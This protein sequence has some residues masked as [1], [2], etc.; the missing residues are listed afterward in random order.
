MSERDEHSHDALTPAEG[1]PSVNP[2]EKP[3]SF[4]EH[5]EELRGTIIKS[6]VT[7]VV[8][9]VL[10]GIFIKQFS[11]ALMWPLTSVAAEYPELSIK[12]VT[13][14]MLEPFT[15][16]IQLC[17]LGALTLSL[18]FVLFYIAQFVAPALTERET[19]LVVPLCISV[20]VLF[21]LGA[22]FGFFL[23]M[24][25]TVRMSIELIESFELGFMWTVGKYY[26]TLTWLVLGVGATFQFPL[27]LIVLVWLGVITTDFMRKYRRHAIVVIFV[28]AA[29]VTPTPDPLTQTVFAAPLYAF[30]EI[31]ILVSSRIEKRRAA[32][33]AGG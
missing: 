32:E 8:F 27:V 4:W 29:I 13:Q 12:L 14:S 23:L 33:L 9:A 19:K 7:F 28:I 17:V 30:Y 24:P 22:C 25:S 10:I 2:R 21:L 5:L 3:M 31:A 15:M 26:G 18:P 11:Q 6:V 20:L 1:A 16:I